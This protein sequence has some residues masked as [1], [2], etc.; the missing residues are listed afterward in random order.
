ML[1]VGV[2]LTSTVLCRIHRYGPSF[3]ANHEEN[4]SL[5]NGPISLPVSRSDDVDQTICLAVDMCYS[6]FG[7]LT[8]AQGFIYSWQ[9]L[10]V[11]RVF[12]GV[13]EGA[14]LP[15]TLFLLQVWYTRFEFHKRQAAYYLVGIA[16]SGLSGLL[17]YGIEKMDG[18]AGIEGWRWM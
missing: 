4:R 9:Q 18:T 1:G 12:L 11:L 16:S 8:I 5:N 14:L 17:A 13:F 7:V 3:N 2:V 6:G 15:A 10:A